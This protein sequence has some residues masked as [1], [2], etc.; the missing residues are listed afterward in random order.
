MN[1]LHSSR[2]TKAFSCLLFA[3]FFC[4]ESDQISSR[5]IQL[6]NF[7]GKQS[8][9]ICKHRVNAKR[10]RFWWSWAISKFLVWMM[11]KSLEAVRFIA[12][13]LLNFGNCLLFIF[14]RLKASGRY[15]GFSIGILCFKEFTFFSNSLEIFWEILRFLLKNQIFFETI[16]QDKSLSANIV[17]VVMNFLCYQTFTRSWTIFRNTEKWARDCDT[18]FCLDTSLKPRQL[19]LF[20]EQ[21]FNFLVNKQRSERQRKRFS[22]RRHFS[23]ALLLTFWLKFPIHSVRYRGRKE[24]LWTTK[25][26]LRKPSS[27]KSS[28][29][30]TKLNSINLPKTLVKKLFVY[31]LQWFS[32]F[33]VCPTWANWL[34]LPACYNPT[35]S[36]QPRENLI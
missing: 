7:L 18:W 32:C 14:R 9:A 16:S 15:W 27:R 24:S 36:L 29:Y 13:R 19:V 3:R 30:F 25:M 21:K 8:V 12:C 33:C 22:F 6:A 20:S 31:I 5:S 23:L 11:C 28:I 4:A 1:V 26:K 2:S 35:A 17:V 10:N 34:K